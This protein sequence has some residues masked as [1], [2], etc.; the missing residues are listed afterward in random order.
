MLA[1]FFFNY[2]FLS[3]TL[4]TLVDILRRDGV[5]VGLISGTLLRPF[6]G[7]ELV[8]TVLTRAPRAKIIGVF[9]GTLDPTF[10][11]TF[12]DLASAFQM[13][14][15]EYARSSPLLINFKYGGGRIL[16]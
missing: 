16:L 8:E 15:R 7:Q 10:G 11:A 14:G 6:P 3:G 2:G 4:R 12:T 13:Y 5:P 9:D 1:T